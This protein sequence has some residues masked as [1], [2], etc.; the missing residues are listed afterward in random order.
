M[1]S[2]PESRD[3]TNFE[4][5]QPKPP[6]GSV[7]GGINLR[8][9]DSDPLEPEPAAGIPYGQE[10]SPSGGKEPVLEAEVV[11]D[12]SSTSQVSRTANRFID[13]EEAED[14]Q[15]RWNEI[16]VAFVDEPRSAVQRANTLVA[17]TTK[18][19]ADSFA[20]GRQ[21]LEKDWAEGSDVSTETL[22]LALQRYRLLFNRL[23]AI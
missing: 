13:P 21:K 19:L 1:N 7:I 18:L 2:K 14:L 3:K 12:E 22:R 9:T 23:M 10:P 5:P 15:S 16:L 20:T 11:D 6:A 8:N 17:E 4:R